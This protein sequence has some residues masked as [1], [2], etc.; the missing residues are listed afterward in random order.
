MTGKWPDDEI[1][2]WDLDTLNNRWGNLREA[3]HG[4]NQANSRAYKNNRSGVKGVCFHKMEGK[5]RAQVNVNGKRTYLGSFETI[6]EARAVYNKA[7]AKI[8]GKFA[9]TS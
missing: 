8:F 6:N 2:H 4:Q 5:W 9:R 1:D 3:T 7:A